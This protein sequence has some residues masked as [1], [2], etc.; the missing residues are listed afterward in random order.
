MPILYAAPV[1]GED[2]FQA[3]AGRLEYPIYV[4][5]TV[6]GGE[7]AGCLVGFA[8]QC[9]IEPVRFLACISDKNRTVRVAE[10]AAALAVHLAQEGAGEVLELFGGVTGDEAD[11][12]ARCD[13][14]EG[15]GG[16]PILNAC[17]S[18]FAGR[19]VDRVTLGD[20]VGHVLEPFAGEAGPRA[21]QYEA[22]R[23]RS[24]EPGHDA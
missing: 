11:K 18:W 4:V 3:I 15:P 16:L 1:S 13:W 8:T 5:T 10:R 7:R 14:R 21:P 20:H 2:A 17:P 22:A 6:A 9:S 12:F 24:I 19:I 23:A